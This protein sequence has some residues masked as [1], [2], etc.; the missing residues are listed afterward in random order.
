MGEEINYMEVFGLSEEGAEVT[1]PAEPSGTEVEAGAGEG[2]VAEPL[3]TGTQEP[4]ADNGAGEEGGASEQAQTQSPEDRARFAAARRKAEAERDAAVQKARQDARRDAQKFID[5]AFAS[6]GMVNPYTK[7]PIKTKADFDA[8][9][10]QRNAE[11]KKDFQKRTGMNDEQYAQFVAGL[12]EVRQAAEVK[13]Q[14][15]QA[16]QQIRE[17]QARARLDEQV[18]AINKL[19][20]SIKKLEDVFKTENYSKVYELVSKKGYSLEDAYKIANFDRLTRQTV[21]AAKQQ[22]MNSA[23]G[24]SHMSPTATR[25]AGATAVPADV[26]AE[27]RAMM[28]ELTDAEIQQHYSRYTKK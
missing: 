1:E 17:Q 27:Y 25:G 3:E 9:N 6:M 15:Q 22:A 2:E 28:P 16:Q 13:A 20:P 8:F 19:D 26:A 14:A 23:K 11:Q 21:S 24:K 7:Q 18:K 5:D 4:G 12:P 10:A